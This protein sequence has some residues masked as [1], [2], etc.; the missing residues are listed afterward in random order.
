VAVLP[1]SAF[2]FRRGEVLS[3]GHLVLRDLCVV[4]DKIAAQ[5]SANAIEIDAHGLIIAP[6]FIDLQINGGMGVDFTSAPD[7]VEHVAKELPR[8]GVTAFLATVVSSSLEDY[9][10]ILP[11]IRA[12]QQGSSSARLLGMHLEGPFLHPERCGAH[13]GAFLRDCTENCFSG[14]SGVRL[15]TLAPELR[16]AREMIAALTAQ[17][18]AVSLGHSQASYDEGAEAVKNGASMVTHLFNAMAPFHH[19][20]PG[21]IGLA[22]TH[23]KLYYSII[24]DGLHAHPAAVQLA[25][26]AR[27]EGL[28]LVTD[29]MA[30]MGMQ[31]GQ[32]TLGT[33]KVH[34]EDRRAYIVDEIG[35]SANTSTNASASI[36]AG[37][38]LTMDQAV[39]SLVTFTGCSKARALEAA[40]R[41][42]AEVL[43]IG[44]KGALAIGTDAD[45]VLLNQD[46]QIVAT[47]IGGRCAWSR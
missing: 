2:C 31:E 32:F 33:K 30:A 25:W 23:Q 3:D 5:P 11:R 40:S 14:L 41:R 16:G 6:G 8:Y 21:L 47:Y 7:Q 44:T 46:L 38:T 18:I 43:G 13:E 15:I 35:A 24:A 39:R 12:T 4:N 34:V 1:D 9:R 20:Q 37:S 26:R 19:R 29:A 22:L 45:I 27:P 10:N 17:N 42:P 36:L 28:V